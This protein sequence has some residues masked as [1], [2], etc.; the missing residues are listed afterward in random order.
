MVLLKS[1]KELVLTGSQN[2][3]EPRN[4]LPVSKSR[5]SQHTFHFKSSQIAGEHQHIL[6]VHADHTGWFH[7]GTKLAADR[8]TCC[9][10]VSVATIAVLHCIG[11]QR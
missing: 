6:A 9:A 1:S 3:W 7:P 11:T 2:H 8:R 10:D 5:V 4:H